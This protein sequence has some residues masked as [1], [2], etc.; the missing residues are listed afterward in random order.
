MSPRLAEFILEDGPTFSSLVTTQLR[1]IMSSLSSVPSEY[2]ST[3]ASG[4]L[5][6]FD[7]DMLWS[8][9][10]HFEGLDRVFWILGLTLILLGFMAWQMNKKRTQRRSWGFRLFGIGVL[11]SIIGANY[12]AFW[13]LLYHVLTQ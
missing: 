3:S 1:H 7:F 6:Q 12:S 11:F 10:E 8:A 13:N 5:M 2:A 9:F 4:P